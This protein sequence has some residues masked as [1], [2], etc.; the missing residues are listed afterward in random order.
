MTA[1]TF[2][3]VLDVA[4]FTRDAVDVAMA[5]DDPAA[6]QLAAHTAFA[7][8]AGTAIDQLYDI[9]AEELRHAMLS[10]AAGTPLNDLRG[11][12]S[13]ALHTIMGS[14]PDSW[15]R[16][17]AI[18]IL[19]EHFDVDASHF[20]Q[21][22]FGPAVYGASLINFQKTLRPRISPSRYNPISSYA[23]RF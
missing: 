5:G 6:A 10:V 15:S 4:G 13:P 9:P 22:Q 14:T 11:A 18:A 16:S 1:D 8:L 19:S 3:E 21:E 2:A 12:I 20:A 23:M 7:S 17:Q